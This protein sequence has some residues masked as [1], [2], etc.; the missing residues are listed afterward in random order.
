MSPRADVSGSDAAGPGSKPTAPKRCI[1]QIDNGRL[2]GSF[3]DQNGWK[4]WFQLHGCLTGDPKLSLIF[5]ANKH[6]GRKDKPLI[7][8]SDEHTEEFKLNF[9]PGLKSRAS[10]DHWMMEDYEDY[11]I[12]TSSDQSVRPP[13]IVDGLNEDDARRIFFFRFVCWDI[14]ANDKPNQAVWRMYRSSGITDLFDQIWSVTSH[15]K[16][17]VIRIWVRCLYDKKEESVKEAFRLAVKQQLSPYVQ[18]FAP[19]GSRD[20]VEGL[21]ISM[22]DKLIEDDEFKAAQERER[23]S[24]IQALPQSERDERKAKKAAKDERYRS[25]ARLDEEELRAGRKIAFAPSQTKDAEALGNLAKSE[26]VRKKHMGVMKGKGSRARATRLSE[27]LIVDST[28]F[29]DLPSE[30]VNMI[31]SYLHARDLENWAMTNKL[32]RQFSAQ[33]MQ[34]HRDLKQ[35]YSVIRNGRRQFGSLAW[36]AIDLFWNP[37]HALYVEVLKIHFWHEDGHTVTQITAIH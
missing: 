37:I 5:R 8:D 19:G 32:N 25:W 21:D 17:R 18:S 11:D 27:E 29:L 13:T 12:T 14:P 22:V 9:R 30:F 24:A 20:L 2:V 28:S 34:S 35:R 6:E 1:I 15:Q 33:H 16:Q 3:N 7:M 23:L 36:L 10:P 26:K 4:V 31:P